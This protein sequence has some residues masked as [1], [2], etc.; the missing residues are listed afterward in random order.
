[1]NLAKGLL[2][3]ERLHL[4]L[5]KESGSNSPFARPKDNTCRKSGILKRYL[6]KGCTRGK[7]K[8]KAT[9]EEK[10]DISFSV[11]AVAPTDTTVTVTH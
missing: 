2:I 10:A 5:Y 1:M 6:E 11:V 7:I 8:I 9:K 4:S 3:K